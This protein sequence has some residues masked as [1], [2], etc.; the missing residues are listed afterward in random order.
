MFCP[1]RKLPPV[2]EPDSFAGQFQNQCPCFR[3]A[4]T[5]TLGVGFRA[6]RFP[7]PEP[8]SRFASWSNSCGTGQSSRSGQK[9]YTNCNSPIV[10]LSRRHTVVH[11]IVYGTKYFFG[12]P[13]VCE[14]TP[15]RHLHFMVERLV[16]LHYPP[17]TCIITFTKLYILLY[18]RVHTHSCND[19]YVRK[20]SKVP[21]LRSFFFR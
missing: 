9:I 18:I 1:D 4:W 11:F 14:A 12:E 13:L 3:I 20:E 10:S 2:P 16:V 5:N 8:D 15:C 21:H 17:H 7:V 6:R 19:V